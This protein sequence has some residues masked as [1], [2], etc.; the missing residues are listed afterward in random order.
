MVKMLLS[1]LL[2]AFITGCQSTKGPLQ[3]DNDIYEKNAFLYQVRND[4]DKKNITYCADSHY[5]PINYNYLTL[6]I[7]DW[8]FKRSQ[9]AFPYYN[10]VYDCE[11]IAWSFK[12]HFTERILDEFN[13]GEWGLAVGIGI[14]EQKNAWGGT[15]R[16]TNSEVLLHVVNFV[17]TDR[18]WFVIEP[19]NGEIISLQHYPNKDYIQYL[20][21]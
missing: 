17:L 2:L 18:G 8:K 5:C 11:D 1:L 14:V 3:V 4:F 6:F 12:V 15:E 19:A 21:F 9:H 16:G 7:D 13:I 20:H 10:N